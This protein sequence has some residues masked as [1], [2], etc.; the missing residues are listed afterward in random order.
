MARMSFSLASCAVIAGTLPL[1][2]LPQIPPRWASV[3]V[4]M[5]STLLLVTCR[6]KIVRVLSLSSLCLA[7]ALLDARSMLTTMVSIDGKTL[8]AEVK[9]VEMRISGHQ[10]QQILVQVEKLQGRWVFPAFYAT[11]TLPN[12]MQA[13]CGG[14]RWSI[15]ARF[16]PLHSRLNQGGFDRQ[17]WGIAKRQL[18]SARVLRATPITLA[19]GVRQ[20]LLTQVEQHA[21]SL[22]WHAILLALMFGVMKTLTPEASAVLQQ[23]GTM[24]LMVISG[25][26]IVL[27]AMFG[28]GLM[29]ALQRLL[30]LRWIVPPLPLLAGV[31]LAWSYAWLAGENPPAI[32]AA[33]AYSVWTLIRWR[34]VICT[35]WQVWLWCVAIVFLSEPMM[36]LSNSF[37]LSCVAV[38]GLIF[39]FQWA[40]LPYGLRQGWHWVLVR[41]AHLQCGITLLLLPLQWGIFK[42][43]SLTSLPANIWAVPLVSFVTTPLVLVAL[44]LALFP[45]LSF[46]SWWLADRSLDVVFMVL[47]PLKR[48]WIA[49]DEHYL[50]WSLMGWCGVIIWR[51]G[52]WRVYPASVAALVLYVVLQ[53]A[54]TPQP[55]WRVDM[56]DVGHGLAIVIERE[57]QTV[58]FDTGSQWSG[59]DMA[60]YEILPYLRWRGITPEAVI[61]SH[62]HQDHIGGL[63]S[64]LQAYPGLTVYSPFTQPGHRA[65]IQGETWQWQGLTFTV[66]WPPIRVAH[67][68]NDDSCVVRIDDGRHRVLLTGDIE[69]KT[70][71]RL[72]SAL[73]DQLTADLLQIPH[74][75]S[76]TSSSAPFLRAVNPRYALASTGRYNPWRLPSAA[77]IA[78]YRNAGHHWVD[79][80]QSGQVSV[81]FFNEHLLVLPYRERLSPFWYHQWFGVKRDSE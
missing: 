2:W 60:Q 74:H 44:P 59:G 19:C 80:A 72:E 38:A 22:Q 37:W 10:D 21:S 40:P 31:L 39:W 62:S 76:K 18:A 28:W 77:V 53:R 11:L 52:W 25:L 66:L 71:R 81:R 47:K 5:I 13:W 41:V 48:G 68:G 12:T 64:L 8:S 51:F 57:G 67:A 45:T 61:L 4:L 17:R 27:A 79:T 3:T 78:R 56:L 73:R 20:R 7:F 33:L 42:G 46:S 34:G 50:A 32:R 55:E 23:T 69:M 24:H 75:G 29:R 36:V 6:S 14:Q 43:I 9:I 1:L 58:L 26:H 15:R 49:I 30:P 54:A 70:E 65:C 35:S 16:R 63:G